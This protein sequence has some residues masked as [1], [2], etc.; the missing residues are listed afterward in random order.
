MQR[1]VII[2][3]LAAILAVVGAVLLIQYVRGADERALAGQQTT[4]VLVVSK[5]IPLG[6]PASDIA[7]SVQAKEVPRAVV[8]P[9]A[10]T[11]LGQVPAGNVTNTGLK[12]GEQLLAT[13]FVA[14]GSDEITAQVPVPEGMQALSIQLAPERVLGSKLKAGD[15]VGVIVSMK[16]KPVGAGTT[17]DTPEIETTTVVTN[18]VLV[19]G[20]QGALAPTVPDAS[21]AAEKAPS[22]EV[23][24][25]VAVDP[26]TAEKIIFGQE[27]GKVW[28]TKQND[29][30][31]TDGSKPITAK[32]VIYP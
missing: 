10:V 24:I 23:V 6:T 30:T 27:F 17:A 29:Q 32:D 31:K 1:R 25:T 15:R 19:V 2:G 16:V 20:A 5:D 22:G 7:G 12:V 18:A 11:D 9:G 3:V 4:T 8:V 21:T 28:L 26:L 13:R 14:P